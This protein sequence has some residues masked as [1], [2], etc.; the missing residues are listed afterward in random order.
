MGR[1]FN[2]ISLQEKQKLE[3]LNM[4]A[5]PHTS[6]NKKKTVIHRDRAVNMCSIHPLRAEINV[7]IHR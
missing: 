2:T 1:P 6:V 3:E 7:V 4:D 5:G